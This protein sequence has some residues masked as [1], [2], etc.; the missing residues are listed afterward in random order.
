[1]AQLTTIEAFSAVLSGFKSC[2]IWRNFQLRQFK[3]AR[4]DELVLVPYS[5][6]A[7]LSHRWESVFAKRFSSRYRAAKPYIAL[8]LVTR[9]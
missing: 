2:R 6:D 3:L 8:A 1:M 4:Y 9:S 5:Y 7:R